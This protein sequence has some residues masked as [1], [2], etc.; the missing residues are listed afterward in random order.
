MLYRQSEVDEN[1]DEIDYTQSVVDVEV[2]EEDDTQCNETDN[3]CKESTGYQYIYVDSNNDIANT[4]CL[5]HS[6]CIMQLMDLPTVTQCHI[7]I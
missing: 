4:F 7:M 2:D 3:Q 1:M 6:D 5:A